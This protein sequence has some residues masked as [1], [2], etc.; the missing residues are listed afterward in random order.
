MAAVAKQTTS[1]QSSTIISNEHSSLNGNNDHPQSDETKATLESKS[2]ESFPVVFHPKWNTEHIDW[3]ELHH[4]SIEKG[5]ILLVEHQIRRHYSNELANFN[6]NQKALKIGNLPRSI[7]DFIHL[8]LSESAIVLQSH[9][10]LHSHRNWVTQVDDSEGISI[11][12]RAEDTANGIHSIKSRFTAKCH[13]VELI[14]VINEFDLISEIITLVPVETRYL[15]EFTELNKALYIKMDLWFPFKNRD[16]VAQVKAY[17]LLQ[18]H[19]EVLLWGQ[20]VTEQQVEGVDVPKVDKKTVRMECKMG[21]GVIKP[22]IM[23]NGNLGVDVIASF[24]IDFKMYLPATLLN[25]VT[26]TFAFYA[27]KMIRERTENLEGTTHQQRIAQ[28]PLYAEW[29]QQF[30]EWKVRKLKQKGG[31]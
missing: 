16:A 7:R 29:K 13:P 18:D 12:Y 21:E 14:A 5:R 26:R 11:Y 1:I 15:K 2:P 30:E 27:V 8:I 3:N 4:L 9:R 31:H 28:N 19:D 22:R 17:D 10:M 23:Q 24:N 25:W 20:S 6:P